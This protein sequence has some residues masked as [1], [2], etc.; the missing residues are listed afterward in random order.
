MLRHAAQTLLWHSGRMEN[1]DKD[2]A[3]V[4]HALW[5][6][7]ARLASFLDECV[8][9][10]FNICHDPR[11]MHRAIAALL[12]RGLIEAHDGSGAPVSHAAVLEMLE[13]GDA[14]ASAACRLGL[15][16]V[17]GAA[18]EALFR[19]RW[20]A[21]VGTDVRNMDGQEWHCICAFNRQRLEAAAARLEAAASAIEGVTARL[22]IAPAAA[23]EVVYWKK[24]GGWRAILMDGSGA[25]LLDID[26]YDVSFGDTAAGGR[27]HE[28]LDAEGNEFYENECVM[29][30]EVFER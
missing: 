13:G 4:L 17:G 16:E 14:E 22:E 15:T 25:P 10:R 8:A 27:F 6:L 5:E 7:R 24:T 30:T 11:D 29:K 19:P 3:F 9:E 20:D 23:G 28:V 18:W 21:Y 12:V 2:E 26:D 1:M